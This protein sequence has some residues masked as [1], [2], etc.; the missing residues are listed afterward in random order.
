MT[1]QK[2]PRSCRIAAI[3]VGLTK[4]S[5]ENHNPKFHSGIG[6]AFYFLHSGRVKQECANRQ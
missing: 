4:V 1:E 6:S 2:I 3:Q 5:G